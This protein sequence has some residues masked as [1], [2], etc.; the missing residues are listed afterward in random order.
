MS[1]VPTPSPVRIG[2]D[3]GAQ[4]TTV[5]VQLPRGGLGFAQLG[6][7]PSLAARCQAAL[8]AALRLLGEGAEPPE[9][10]VTYAAAATTQALLLGPPPR[11]ALLVTAGF[12]DVLRIGRQSAA[13]PR[14]APPL[15]PGV[16][17][18][19]AP[20]A[21]PAHCLPVPERLAADGAV[22][23]PLTAEALTA[24]REQLSRL[25]VEAAAVMLLHSSRDDQ[26]E[27]LVAQALGELGL[28]LAC[29]AAVLPAADELGRA[30]AAVLAAAGA[31]FQTA[32]E[33]A[34]QAALPRPGRV[35]RVQS[36]GSA[37]REPP[38]LRGLLSDVAAGLVGAHKAAVALETP[39]CLSLGV[40]DTVS[41][42]AHHDG[43]L[44]LTSRAQLAGLP[45]GVPTLAAA[46]RPLGGES[47]LYLASDGRW[48]HATGE[49]EGSAVSPAA[50]ARFL[51]RA[52]DAAALAGGSAAP[53]A[54]TAQVL[55]AL[56]APRQLD[57]AAVA[58]A[59]LAAVAAQL[60]DAVWAVSVE[61][62]LDPADFPLLAYGRTGGLLAA[63]VAAQLGMR[64][65]VIPPAA[66]LL[67]AYGAL[68]APVLRERSRLLRCEASG[69]QQRGLL[70]GTLRALSDELRRDLAAEGRL[71]RG[72]LTGL[73]WSADLRYA[74]QAHTL[75][76]AGLGEGGPAPDGT[77]D[78]VVRFHQ[79][80]ERRYGFTLGQRPVE[81]EQVRVRA[82]APIV[83]PS[84]AQLCQLAQETAL[85]TAAGPAGPAV[86][87]G[88]ILYGT[89][90]TTPVAGPLV[91]HEDSA[92]TFVPAGWTAELDKQ[93]AIWLRHGA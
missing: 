47:R 2:L 35:R 74:G 20:A 30:A 73:Q 58:T 61:R 75:T 36:D 32:E 49:S 81:L 26:H 43:V 89:L 33:A 77:T 15:E 79:E 22:V 91:I 69:A 13:V 48:A 27:Q 18:P 5:L 76:L 56:G 67:T 53:A 93:G 88:V 68:C 1:A 87:A 46:L 52:W 45:L 3:L 65:V 12:T 92:S 51:G 39:R 23:Q 82:A 66:G 55:A 44:A 24:L 40:G 42:A 54:A 11:V 64:R 63:A 41:V 7:V 21:L 71:E 19:A 37:R 62:G 14:P 16:E 10:E 38:P 83:G 59:L 9:L 25:E 50:A 78:L 86:P 28:P 17:G 4:V 90:A 70:E 29:S 31:V 8:A 34:L 80:H 72:H 85:H 6:A 84:F 57:A 60:A